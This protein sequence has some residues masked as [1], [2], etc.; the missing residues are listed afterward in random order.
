MNRRKSLEERFWKSLEL[1][2]E[3]LDSGISSENTML[4]FFTP[5]NGLTIYESFC[6]QNF[7]K[8]LRENYKAPGYF[9]GFAAQAFVEG[10]KNGVL[11]RSDFDWPADCI[12]RRRTAAG[13]VTN[14]R[15]AV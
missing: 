10:E 9:H 6:N 13:A 8:Y 5:S 12:L 2:N 4:A 1:F 7:P 14:G 11:I 3:V 15:R